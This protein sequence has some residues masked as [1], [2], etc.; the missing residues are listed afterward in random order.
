MD[1]DF[2]LR[3][4]L[5]LVLHRIIQ[6]LI[7]HLLIEKIIKLVYFKSGFHLAKAIDTDVK[8]F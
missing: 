6:L 7:V 2:F 4:L 3:P 1:R 5:F 8:P